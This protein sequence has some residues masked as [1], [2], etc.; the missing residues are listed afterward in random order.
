MFTRTTL[1]DNELA[2]YLRGRRDEQNATSDALNLLR[3][4]NLLDVAT[5]NLILEYLD[6]LD[7]RPRK[8]EE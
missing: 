7:R 2:I 5:C 4:Q 8:E 1:L 6:T 3:V